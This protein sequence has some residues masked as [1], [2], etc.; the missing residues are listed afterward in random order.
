MAD[1]EAREVL[2]QLAQAVRRIDV[3]L[4]D[5]EQDLSERVSQAVAEML[6]DNGSTLH[7]LIAAAVQDRYDLLDAKLEYCKARQ[8]IDSERLTKVSAWSEQMVMGQLQ[9]QNLSRRS[10]EVEPE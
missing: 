8:D 3:R 2:A 4:D 6:Q 5:L 1:G 9:E 10:N 7:G